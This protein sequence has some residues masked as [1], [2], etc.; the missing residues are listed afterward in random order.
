V[1]GSGKTLIY[2]VSLRDRG[3]WTSIWE[4]NGRFRRIA[5]HSGHIR[6]VANPAG[7]KPLLL[8][9][10]SKGIFFFAGKMY[11]MQHEGESRLVK[12]NPL[13]NFKESQFYT[14]SIFHPAQGGIPVFVGLGQHGQL[15]MWNQE[16]DV[17]WR[18]DHKIGGTNNAVRSGDR[19]TDSAA[20][21]I[22]LN[23][24]TVAF[25]INK[26]GKQEIIAVHN[27]AFLDRFENLRLFDKSQLLAY[28]TA[29]IGLTHAWKTPT[30][31]YCVM[32]I[33]AVNNTL[34]VLGQKASRSMIHEGSGRIL[35]FE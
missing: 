5:D 3:A 34:F 33:Q 2:L 12:K 18:D 28:R 9:Q 1:E 4:W 21:M 24:R 30:I 11:L 14:L 19:P 8:F 32:D 23:S 25:D 26:D 35:W 29:G 31:A 15:H 27:E 10:D 16:G 13:P 17:L 7:H 22:Y 6:V 20:P